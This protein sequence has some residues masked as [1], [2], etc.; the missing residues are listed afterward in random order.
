VWERRARDEGKTAARRQGQPRG[1]K[2]DEK[3]DFLLDLVAVRPLITLREMQQ[4]LYDERGLSAGIGTLWR[5]I[6]ARAITFKQIPARF[7]TGPA[8]HR[9]SPRSLFDRQLDFHPDRPVFIDEPGASTKMARLRVVPHLAST[10]AG[11]PHGHWKTTTFV[12][13]LRL[14]GLTA[15]VPLDGPVTA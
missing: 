7:R 1:S 2:L 14:T 12:A 11:V 15:P 9:R 5:F 10:C 6:A 13:G 8:G 4:R 3:A